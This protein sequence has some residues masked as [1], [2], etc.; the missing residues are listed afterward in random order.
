MYDTFKT[1]QFCFYKIVSWYQVKCQMYI[2]KDNRPIPNDLREYRDQSGKPYAW[3][4]IACLMR[5][6]EHK[7]SGK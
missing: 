2:F 6:S 5:E 3:V 4:P 1:N 7:A